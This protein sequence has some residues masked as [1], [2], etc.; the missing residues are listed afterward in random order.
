MKRRHTGAL[1]PNLAVR[2]VIGGGG[3]RECDRRP[4][5]CDF[6]AVFDAPELGLI[7]ALEYD[8]WCR[9]Q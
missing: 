1:L 3:M 2:R 9:L 8:C 5:I 6:G 4:G 7:T